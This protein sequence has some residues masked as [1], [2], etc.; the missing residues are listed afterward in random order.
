MK[1]DVFS[2]KLLLDTV[3]HRTNRAKI[4]TMSG[5]VT[6]MNLTIQVLERILEYFLA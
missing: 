1:Q 4:G 3:C 6:I 2:L 5:V